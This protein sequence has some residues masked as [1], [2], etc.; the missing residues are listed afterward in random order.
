MGVW[1]GGGWNANLAKS[2]EINARHNDA[3]LGIFGP[4][5]SGPE[6]GTTLG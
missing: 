6:G 3:G 1:K 5:K 4:T 2:V